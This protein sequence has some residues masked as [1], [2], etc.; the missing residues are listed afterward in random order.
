MT[1]RAAKLCGLDTARTEADIRRILSPFQDQGDCP[2]W[3]R[4]AVAFCYDAGLLDPDTD[5]LLPNEPILRCE[6]AQILY[7]MMDQAALL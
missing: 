1:A 3:A 6:M 7:R 2:D 5:M 4:E